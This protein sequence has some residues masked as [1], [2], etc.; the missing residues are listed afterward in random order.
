MMIST[1]LELCVRE[2]LSQHKLSE[3]LFVVLLLMLYYHRCLRMASEAL[4][5]HVDGGQVSHSWCM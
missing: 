4:E 1:V 2:A 5:L 3:L